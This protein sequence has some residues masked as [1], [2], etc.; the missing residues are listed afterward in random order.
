MQAAVRSH[1]TFGMFYEHYHD[2]HDPFFISTCTQTLGATSVVRRPRVQKK[3]TYHVY[4]ASAV[5]LRGTRT[6]N[7]LRWPTAMSLCIK[8]TGIACLSHD[9]FTT[10]HNLLHRSPKTLLFTIT[11]TRNFLP[12]VFHLS[13]FPSFLSQPGAQ[14]TAFLST[15]NPIVGVVSF[16]LC[17]L[18]YADK[19]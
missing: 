3:F 12:F 4:V 2:G 8:V 19:P 13:N 17:A 16:F 7:F 11:T 9:H 10:D 6:G 1:E 14:S 18:N 5:E 15:P